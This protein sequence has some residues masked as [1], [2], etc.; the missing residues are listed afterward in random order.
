MFRLRLLIQR[1]CGIVAVRYKF[2]HIKEPLINSF[3][4]ARELI[5]GS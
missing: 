5:R 4:T 1:L 2:T 3:A